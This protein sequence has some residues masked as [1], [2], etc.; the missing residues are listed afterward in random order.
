MS[1]WAGK[2][3][4]I[5]GGAGFLGSHLVTELAMRGVTLSQL[6]VPRSRDLDLR[7]W[8]GCVEAVRDPDLTG[9]TLPPCF[10]ITPSWASS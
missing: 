4:L 6:R 10:T 3:I 8:E 1:F 2:K 7:K 5:T 9:T